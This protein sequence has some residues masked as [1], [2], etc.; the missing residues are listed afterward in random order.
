MAKVE[1]ETLPIEKRIGN[2]LTKGVYYSFMT[3]TTHALVG[4]IIAASISDPAIGLPLAAASHPFLDMVPHWD[5]GLGWKKK[6]KFKLFIESLLDLLVGITLTFIIFGRITDPIYLTAAI[7]MSEIWDIMM[8]PYL[9][10]NWKFF[11]FSLFYRFGH[12]TNRS[13]KLPWGIMTQIA[14]VASFTF[15]F[16]LLR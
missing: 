16:R 3:A 7:F 4:G 1:T 10:L 14:A 5:F 13:L 15:A 9:L 2:I 8:M 11:P 6:D 12:F